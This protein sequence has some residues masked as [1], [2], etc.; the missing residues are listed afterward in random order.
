MV[1]IVYKQFGECSSYNG[2]NKHVEMSVMAR[3]D[4]F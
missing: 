4:T 1:E 2:V 3:G